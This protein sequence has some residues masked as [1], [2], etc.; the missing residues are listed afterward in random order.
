MFSSFKKSTVN[1]LNNTKQTVK[2][3]MTDAKDTMEGKKKGTFTGAIQ[4][5]LS[6]SSSRKHE[7][8]DARFGE[9]TIDT[10][11]KYTGMDKRTDKVQKCRIYLTCENGKKLLDVIKIKQQEILNA[12]KTTVDKAK[13]DYVKKIENIVNEL[14]NNA[15]KKS[16]DICN[17]IQNGEK[18]KNNTVT[19]ADTQKKTKFKSD[20]ILAENEQIDCLYLVN[21]SKSEERKI[22]SVNILNKTVGVKLNDGKGIGSLKTSG[23]QI[24]EIQ[25]VCIGGK[26][27]AVDTY[28][29]SCNTAITYDQQNQTGGSKNKFSHKKHL[30]MD[31]GGGASDKDLDICE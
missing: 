21:S 7:G 15:T 12:H 29:T 31:L 27:N 3:A 8:A 10:E 9:F 20:I 23:V 6:L 28:D 19:V 1:A 14:K 26:S 2:T 5:N 17:I 16:N 13:N 11:G 24:V 30:N 4:N 18:E 25:Y 22:V